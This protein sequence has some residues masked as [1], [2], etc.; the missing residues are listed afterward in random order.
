MLPQESPSSLAPD[1]QHLL[2]SLPRPLPL[3]VVRPGLV[4]V[5]GLP[6]TGK[7]YFSRRLAQRVPLAVVES[8]AMR[9]ALSP[10]PKY[11]PEE[12]LR[13]FTAIHGLIDALLAEGVPVLLDATTLMEAH[14]EPLYQI[15]ERRKAWVVL[16]MTAAPTDVVR[17]RLDIRPR[18]GE[19]ADSS[20]ADFSVYERMRYAQ[21]P[22]S[23]LHYRV[24]T[25]RDIT[26]V[27]D[28]VVADIREKMARAT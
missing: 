2:D 10:T 23:R 4:I 24:D 13:I 5:S 16:V 14:R 15:A 25:T 7:S 20:D 6:G 3:P 28:R 18:Q 17:Q 19:R 27:V 21:E 8:D 9:K 12:S 11:T 26:P 22:P 1:V